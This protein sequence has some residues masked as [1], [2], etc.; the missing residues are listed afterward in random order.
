M[1]HPSG[2]VQEALRWRPAKSGLGTESF[3]ILTHRH[4]HMDTDTRTSNLLHSQGHS[5]LGMLTEEGVD[6]LLGDKSEEFLHS[7]ITIP[8]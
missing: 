3:N 5:A 1:G 6:V 7:G 4:T 2:A 8:P